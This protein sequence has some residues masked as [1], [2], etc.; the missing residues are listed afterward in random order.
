MCMTDRCRRVEEALRLLRDESLP[1]KQRVQRT[2]PGIYELI[3]DLPDPIGT[4]I[5]G[6][7]A[8]VDPDVLSDAEAYRLLGTLHSFATLMLASEQRAQNAEPDERLPPDEVVDPILAELDQSISRIPVDAIRQAREHRERIVPGLI[9][10]IRRATADAAGGG[11]LEGH[12]QLFALLLLAEFRAKE[13]LPAILDAVSLPG[14]LPFDLFDDEAIPEVLARVLAA[15]ADDRP[16]AIDDLIRSPLRNEHV[17]WSAAL[18]FRLL[19]RAG[20]L[21]RDEVLQRLREHLRRAIEHSDRQI[22][23]PLIDELSYYT[24]RE[25]MAEIEQAY[26]EGLVDEEAIRLSD[27]REM[28]G[29][30]D[31]QMRAL[32]DHLEPIGIDDTIAELQKW[33]TFREAAPEPPRAPA[34]A[35]PSAPPRAAPPQSTSGVR[36]G[37]NDP[38]PCGSGR[39]HKKCCGARR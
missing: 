36:I 11:L 24:P 20:K 10:L 23:V 39:K 19:V 30:S 9:Q 13:A 28:L 37:R 31:A 29:R 26:R 3:G 21:G 17:R 27:V 2:L 33:P 38:C 34:P 6:T 22:I 4:L 16:D 35:G 18:A 8:D 7:L 1:V 25:A 5:Q 14:E 12:G 15:L 32:W